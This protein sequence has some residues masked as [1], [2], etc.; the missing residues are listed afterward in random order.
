MMLLIRLIV[1]VMK[2]VLPTKKEELSGEGNSLRMFFSER[3]LK[4]S[5]QRTA[6]SIT[7]GSSDLEG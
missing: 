5:H 2:K 7:E 3:L 6:N 1:P 4:L